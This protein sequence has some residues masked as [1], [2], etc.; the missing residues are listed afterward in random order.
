VSGEQQ[1]DTLQALPK[2]AA[3]QESLAG[4]QLGHFSG[5]DAQEVHDI[6]LDVQQS[7]YR[8]GAPAIGSFA[9]TRSDA[10]TRPIAGSFTDKRNLQAVT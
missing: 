5:L 4:E 2:G 1:F 7:F 8:I 3:A 10:V 6:L 9:Y